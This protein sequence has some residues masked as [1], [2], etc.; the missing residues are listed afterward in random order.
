[1]SSP[2]TTREQ[3]AARLRLD[4]VKWYRLQRLLAIL[5]KLRAESPQA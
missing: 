4:A 1:M 2:I 3:T 5:E